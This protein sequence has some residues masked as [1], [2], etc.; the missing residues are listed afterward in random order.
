MT[1]AIKSI[2]SEISNG[3]LS[4]TLKKINKKRINQVQDQNN[5]EKTRIRSF[6][7]KKL[8]SEAFR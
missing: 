5:A 2:P 1:K 4:P 6:L 8:K 7:C 3:I